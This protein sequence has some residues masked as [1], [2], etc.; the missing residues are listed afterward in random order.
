MGI[1]AVIGS[2]NRPVCLSKISGM[3]QRMLHETSM[4]FGETV[5]SQLGVAAGWVTRSGTFAHGTPF[6]NEDRT[7]VLYFSGEDFSSRDRISDLQRRGHS[8]LSDSAELLVHLYEEKG[9]AFVEELNGWFSGLLVDLREH[10]AILFNDRYGLGRIYYHDSPSGLFLASEAK[11][12]LA[13]IPHLR[14]ID[15]RGLAEFFSVGCVLQ[16]RSLFRG[17]SLVPPGSH[18]TFHRDGRTERR[19]YFHPERWEQQERLDTECYT[20]RL[21]EVF[22]QVAP[23]YFRGRA[24]VAI[25]LTG[26]L[27][28]RMLLAWASMAPGTLPCYTF[29][30]PYRDCADV[31]IARRLAMICGQSH[32]TLPVTDDFFSDF[33]TLAEQTIFRTD[34]AMDV[35]GAVELHVNEKARRIAPV[36]L[37]GNYGSEILRS[38]IA[39]GPSRLDRTGFTPEFEKLLDLAEDTYRAEACGHR[40]SFIA[41]KQMPWHHF[42]R[43]AAEQAIL[44]PRSPF[45]DNDLVSLAYQAP[46]ELAASPAPLLQLIATGNPSLDRVSSD[47]AL[48]HRSVPV[49]SNLAREWQEFTA[50]AEYAY[51]YGMPQR[52]APVD[53]WLRRLRLERLFLGRHKFYHYRIWY[54]EQLRTYLQEQHSPSMDQVG[55]Y[56]EGAGKA[57]IADHITGRR[58]HTSALHKLLSASLMKRLFA[59]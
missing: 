7:I 31:K 37:T 50:K 41:F 36:R 6:W 39:F 27:D 22:S 18:W 57:M 23:R 5:F 28:S 16:D 14:E 20:R 43:L 33:P 10:R 11:S 29:G 40:L 51:D 21:E 38:N 4:S 25:S 53:H 32:T 49:F 45:L 52:F 54:K 35:S 19:R 56:Q 3:V 2:A 55:C 8:G 58:N 47:R 13:V 46:A 34:G 17:I 30:G 42:G 26:G 44:V 48:R 59:P 12:L 15:Q 9:A 24:R 1:C